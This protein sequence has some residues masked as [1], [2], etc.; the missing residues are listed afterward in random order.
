MKIF[1]VIGETLYQDFR[2]T[3]LKCPVHGDLLSYGKHG[4]IKIY[5]CEQDFGTC[6]ELWLHDNGRCVSVTPHTHLTGEEGKEIRNTMNRD[7][8]RDIG[9][10]SQELVRAK[11]YKLPNERVKL[12]LDKRFKRGSRFY[13]YIN[14]KQTEFKLHDIILKYIENG[15][16]KE[17]KILNDDKFLFVVI[18]ED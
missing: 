8:W 11:L 12:L 15:K 1:I 17:K 7:E 10:G 2:F 16:I 6:C 9:D 13:E 18:N 4:D 5:R 3:G 14:G